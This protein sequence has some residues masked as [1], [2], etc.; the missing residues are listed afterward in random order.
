MRLRAFSKIRRVPASVAAAFAIVATPAFA[1][2]LRAE[3][4]VSRAAALTA[5]VGTIARSARDVIRLTAAD[6]GATATALLTPY[7]S[8][9]SPDGLPGGFTMRLPGTGLDLTNGSVTIRHANDGRYGKGF[10]FSLR[11]T[12]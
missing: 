8:T 7:R 5:R 2:S 4:A 1:Q 11:L 10:H 9:P 3:D 6:N 12:Y